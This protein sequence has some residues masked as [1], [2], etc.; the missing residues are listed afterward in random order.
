MTSATWLQIHDGN[1]SPAILAEV[2]RTR[3]AFQRRTPVSPWDEFIAKTASLPNGH[4]EYVKRQISAT[5][6]A[7]EAELK[8]MLGLWV[9]ELEP[10]AV[11]LQETGQL[12]GL[13]C[14]DIPMGAWAPI[15]VRASPGTP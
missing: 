5:L 9:S 11:Y 13:T 1:L 7:R 12:I 14:A 2:E 15:A 10:V 6:N 4:Y 3:F 8:R